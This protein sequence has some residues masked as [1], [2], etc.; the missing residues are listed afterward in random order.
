[1]CSTL[2]SLWVPRPSTE[3][4][5][6]LDRKCWKWISVTLKWKTFQLNLG[7]IQARKLGKYIDFSE[8]SKYQRYIESKKTRAKCLIFIIFLSK[9]VFGIVFGTCQAMPVFIKIIFLLHF[10]SWYI[11]QLICQFDMLCKL[12]YL[13]NL[14]NYNRNWHKQT[15]KQIK[16][17]LGKS[18]TGLVN[19]E[20]WRCEREE[21]INPE[22]QFL[23]GSWQEGLRTP[24]SL[25]CWLLG[26]KGRELPLFHIFQISQHACSSYVSFLIRESWRVYLS[27]D[28]I[29]PIL[30]M[31]KLKAKRG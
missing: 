12:I 17:T 10:I 20:D 2:Q 29:G 24:I 25:A 19:A 8:I 6:L 5:V 15:W 16:L 4:R 1:M 11:Y 27:S 28:M 22:V 31:K 18:I 9:L 13:I 7:F 30:P 26:G 3:I 14:H 21:H 23:T